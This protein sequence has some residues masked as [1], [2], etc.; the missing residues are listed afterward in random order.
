[1]FSDLF[2][3]WQR[4]LRVPRSLATTPAPVAGDQ[5]ANNSAD[6]SWLLSA[7]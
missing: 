7:C 5:S 1:M 3:K 4:T 6:R 2:E